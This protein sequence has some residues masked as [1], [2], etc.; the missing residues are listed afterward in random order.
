MVSP[1]PLH[2]AVLR[3]SEEVDYIRHQLSTNQLAGI[4][5]TSEAGHPDLPHR[6]LTSRRAHHWFTR[7]PPVST[8]RCQPLVDSLRAAPEIISAVGLINS[9]VCG[10]RSPLEPIGYKG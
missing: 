8:D 7:R 5:I 3:G 9:R 10:S 4:V 1:L 2:I 6:R